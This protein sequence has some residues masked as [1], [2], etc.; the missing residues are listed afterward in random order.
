[1]PPRAIHASDLLWLSSR[2]TVRMQLS[3]RHLPLCF[4]AALV[5]SLCVLAAPGCSSS[6]TP[7]VSLTCGD[8]HRDV[9][10]QCDDSNKTGLDGCSATCMFEQVQRMTSFSPKYQADTV[11]GYDAFGSAI[12]STVRSPLQTQIDKAIANGSFSLLMETM[13]A[14]DLTGTTQ[15]S[16]TVG[17]LSATPEQTDGGVTYDGQNDLDWWYSPAA[18]SIDSNRV[19]KT[20]MTGS[21][22]SH[23][24]TLGPS[25]VQFSLGTGAPVQMS[26]LQIISPLNSSSTPKVSTDGHPPGHLSTENLEPTL[27][28]YESSGTST[29][30]GNVSAASLQ[31]TTLPA[32]VAQYCTDYTSANSLLDLI[33]GGCSVALV[34]V[35][36][37]TQP[38]QV[39]ASKPAAGAG[40]P[41]TLTAD[42]NTHIVN[43]CKD[44]NGTS[45]TLSTCIAA[46]AYSAY[47]TFSTD[48]VMFH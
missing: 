33:V 11:C 2:F 47:F 23:V 22:S 37:A 24:L 9:L 10:E 5:V 25:S 20:Q 46:A 40:G 14:T 48:R 29:F 19:P 43:G 8:G 42:S 32:I 26:N 35:V 34:P 16:V 6:D 45:A 1:M 44:A 28:S 41:Y 4:A 3:L 7:P 30:C 21:I 13:N 12:G 27:Q 31:G 38:D 39:D 15:G 17:F 18:A 36:N